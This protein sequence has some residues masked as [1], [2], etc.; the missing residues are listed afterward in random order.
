MCSR[1]RAREVSLAS[2]AFTRS[3][4]HQS[5]WTRQGAFPRATLCCRR[6][7]QYRMPPSDRLSAGT[8]L[9]LATYRGPRSDGCVPPD[10][11]GSPQLP[12]RPSH[13]STPST[14]GGSSALHPQVLRA[15]RGLRPIQPGSAPPC[16]PCGANLVDAAGFPSCCGLVGRS[17]P[18]WGTLSRRYA[19]RLS[20]G[21]GRQLSGSLVFTRTGLSPAGRCGLVRV[22]PVL[23]P[24]LLCGSPAIWV[25]PDSG[26]S[27]VALRSFRLGGERRAEWTSNQDRTD[28]TNPTPSQQRVGGSNPSGRSTQ[29]EPRRAHAEY[30]RQGRGRRHRPFGEDSAVRLRE[31]LRKYRWNTLP[32]DYLVT[33]RA[34]DPVG[35]RHPYSRHDQPPG[36]FAAPC[37]A[38]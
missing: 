16:S 14:P 8:P 10:G 25:H 19:G 28:H 6:R 11:G 34:P 30:H 23:I 35:Y 38:P 21:G 26:S 15:F 36:G 27:L 37:L 33:N 17:S 24:H 22:K 13:H 31:Y 2:S 12:H 18:Q 4:L 32:D 7:H 9:R 5:A 29:R 1:A 3:Y 20:P